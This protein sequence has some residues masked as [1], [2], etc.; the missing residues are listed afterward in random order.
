[1]KKVGVITLNGNYNFGNRLQ[2]YAMQEVLKK[3]TNSVDNIWVA[4]KE[5]FDFHTKKRLFSEDRANKKFNIFC[6]FTN[7]YINKLIH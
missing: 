3:Y 1:M 6:E 7:K 5:K 2:T 4:D